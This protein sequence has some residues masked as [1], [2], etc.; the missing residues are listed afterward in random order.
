[1]A[2]RCKLVHKVCDFTGNPNFGLHVPFVYPAVLDRLHAGSITGEDVVGALIAVSEVASEKM[3]GTS[4][5][6]YSWV[7]LSTHPL[8]LIVLIENDQHFLFRPRSGP[9][10]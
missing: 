2:E 8:R 10:W 4:G 7:S 9:F 1:V 5:A 3:G 6:L